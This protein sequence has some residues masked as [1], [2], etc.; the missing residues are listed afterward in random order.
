MKFGINI[1]N[2]GYFGEPQN[3]TY[4]S[5]LVEKSGW[6]GLFIWD[7]VQA[8]PEWH[9]GLPFI[10]P[11]IALSII[12]MKTEKIF[13]GPYITPLPRRRPWQV[14]RQ[15]TSI[16]HLSKG[17]LML[18]FGIGTPEFD[19]S[20]FGDTSDPKIK[21][22]MLDEA[23]EIINKFQTQEPFSYNGKYYNLNDVLLN[24]GPYKKKIPIFIAGQWPNK[25]PM[26]RAAK[27]DGV[28]PI[29]STWPEYLS[30]DEIN[31]LHQYIVS[32]RTRDDPIE[33]MVGG[34]TPSDKSEGKSIIKKYEKVGMTWW[35][36]D[37]NAIRGPID[38]LIERIETG[39]PK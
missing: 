19:F 26:R 8:F 3:I 2:F 34:I 35:S 23:L 38:E 27:F 10:D 13:L 16:D 7:H 12:S 21:G 22:E 25:K 9:R 32:H 5:E 37:I 33:I 36:E 4:L 30:P 29:S 11:W 39:P 1:P 20:S 14:Y 17:R 18:G 28:V 24:P 31:E 6:D 15:A